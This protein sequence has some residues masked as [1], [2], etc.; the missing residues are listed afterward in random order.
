M[1]IGR[2]EGDLRLTAFEL[3][4]I[5]AEQFDE[6]DADAE[7]HGLEEISVRP[8]LVE[9]FLQCVCEGFDKLSPNGMGVVS[10]P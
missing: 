9:G 8:E 7:F 4:K 2:L 3:L 5:E 1:V 6:R 10:H